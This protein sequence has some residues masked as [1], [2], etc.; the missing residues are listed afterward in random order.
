MEYFASAIKKGVAGPVLL[1][2]ALIKKGNIPLLLAITSHKETQDIRS[3][4]LEA[5]AWFQNHAAQKL[6]EK[7]T[8]LGNDRETLFEALLEEKKI[9][10]LRERSEKG[11]ISFAF[12]AGNC[13]LI[14]GPCACLLQSS[15]GRV[16]A[17][18]LFYSGDDIIIL[19]EGATL[20]LAGSKTSI[21]D[22]RE[23]LE[24]LFFARDEESLERALRE[25]SEDQT[26]IG[27][28][29]IKTGSSV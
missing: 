9:A 29:C 22:D 8:S 27:M 11:E 13:A 2:K 1:E 6:R 20:V 15:F 26:D 12:C 5:G 21:T 25:V 3:F 16:S 7:A 17:T 14:S 24:C 19:E 10:D 4:V 23:R 18:A 28:I